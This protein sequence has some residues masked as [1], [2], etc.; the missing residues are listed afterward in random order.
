LTPRVAD[1]PSDARPW[2]HGDACVIAHFRLTPRSSREAIDGFV[3][4]A[5]GTAIQARV[6]ALPEGGAANKALE[7]LVARWLGVPKSSVALIA[8]GKSR[9]KTLRIAGQP[10]T[11][12]R[13]LVEQTSEFQK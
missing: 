6:R 5:E 2:R 11:L 13:I 12:E 8:G 4:T 7:E 9:V 10:A 1:P 3:E